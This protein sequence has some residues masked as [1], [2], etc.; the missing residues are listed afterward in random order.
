MK[1]LLSLLVVLSVAQFVFA[2]SYP[3]LKVVLKGGIS[4]RVESV[5]TDLKNRPGAGSWCFDYVQQT[6]GNTDFENVEF[7]SATKLDVT[8]YRISNELLEYAQE[9]INSNHLKGT[10]TREVPDA[11]TGCK[12]VYMLTWD[13]KNK[14]GDKGS[15]CVV[16]LD[17]PVCLQSMTS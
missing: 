17:S 3:V 14:F 10:Y 4:G 7:G 16:K 9:Q 11:L 6:L 13:S 15:I 5:V 1:K 8:D 2:D 12:R